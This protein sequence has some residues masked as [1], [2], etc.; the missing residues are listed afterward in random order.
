MLFEKG[1]DKYLV[2]K[3]NVGSEHEGSDEEH[4]RCPLFVPSNFLLTIDL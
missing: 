1:W 2:E 4:A 3:V